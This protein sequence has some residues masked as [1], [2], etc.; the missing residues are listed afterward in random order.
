MSA[1]DVLEQALVWERVL[2]QASQ[3]LVAHVLLPPAENEDAKSQHPLRDEEGGEIQ[4]LWRMHDRV[5]DG[6]SKQRSP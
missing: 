3:V 2:L 6:G 1:H 4:V 5:C